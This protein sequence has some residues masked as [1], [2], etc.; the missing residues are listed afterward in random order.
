M[1]SN[2]RTLC[3]FSSYT[4]AMF[5]LYSVLILS[6]SNTD[7]DVTGTLFRTSASYGCVPRGPCP[8]MTFLPV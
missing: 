6:V 7:A 2:V 8:N 3:S 5:E 4:S 1:N